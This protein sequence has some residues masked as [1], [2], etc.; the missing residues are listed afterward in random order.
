MT[1]LSR[2]YA[3][4]IRSATTVELATKTSGPAARCGRRDAASA[5][6]AW[7]DPPGRPRR[8]PR[9]RGTTG[10]TRSASAC[11]SSRRA[12]TPDGVRTFFAHAWLE[13]ITRSKPPRSNE[14]KA[15]SIS[16][17]SWGY[18]VRAPG[19]AVERRRVH[20]PVGDQRRPRRRV[21]HRR[22][23]LGVG[24]E[25][26]DRHDDLLGAA[27]DRQPLVR[28]CHAGKRPSGPGALEASGHRRRRAR[29]G[30]RGLGSRAHVHCDRSPRGCGH[31]KRVYD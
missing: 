16:G 2:S 23:Q 14:R 15:A 3:R 25:L 19:S 4:R 30:R 24:Q 22:E 12:A 17:S 26:E 21:V 27:R 1:V 31:L 6:A 11:G 8:A 18:C 9:P 10:P 20:G 5:V 13:D 7:S 28:N 29:D